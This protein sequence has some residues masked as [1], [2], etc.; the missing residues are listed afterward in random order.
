MSS[1][2]SISREVRKAKESVGRIPSIKS[3]TGWIKLALIRLLTPVWDGICTV[4]APVDRALEVFPASLY[5]R[6]LG[7]HFG[8]VSGLQFVVLLLGFALI[9]L[10]PYWI[11]YYDQTL[12]ITFTSAALWAIFAMSWDIQSGYTGYISFGHS[13]LSGAAGYTIG[14]LILHVDS[15]LGPLTTIPLAV[16]AS[17]FVGLIIAVPSLRLRGPYFGLI[18]L[19]AVLLATNLIFAYSDWTQ[20]ELGINAV[21]SLFDENWVR[22]Y[23]VAIPMLLIAFVLTYVA[24]SNVGL[25]LMA[26]REN[27]PGIGGALFAYLGKPITP[28]SLVEITNSIEIIAIAVIGGMGSIVGPLFGAFFFFFMEGKLLPDYIDSSAMQRLVLWLLVLGVFLFARNGLFRL[29][30]HAI[31]AIGGDSE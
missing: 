31:G 14:L 11:P 29:I 9:A 17:L 19:V 20:G 18:T 26:I 6:T 3:I 5:N 28:S 30:W 10:A 21:D 2:S 16:L 15:G 23:F 25:V 13:V 27:E 24:R 4:L 7:R 8:K 12:Y 22:Y 1:R